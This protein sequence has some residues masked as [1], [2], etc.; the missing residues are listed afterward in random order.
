MTT[1][2]KTTITSKETLSEIPGTWQL[3]D[4]RS[5]MSAAGFAD[6]DTISE[7]ETR[8]M[9]LMA[10]ADLE[11]AEA[12]N[13]LLSYRLGDDL[14]DGQIDQISHDMQNDKI[15]EEY[16]EIG[17]HRHLFDANQLLRLAY[18]G[19][20][21]NGEAVLVHATMQFTGPEAPGQLTAGLVLRALAPALSD[22]SLIKRLY[23]ADL[24][25][26]TPFEAADNILWEMTA[27]PE[28]APGTFAVRL[29]SSEYWLHDLADS[30]EFEGEITLPE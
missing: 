29:V 22:R 20:F 19:K 21:P 9:T 15:F 25:A 1:S 23:A 14:N 12:A 18:N 10:L 24:E 17:L 16:P 3:T 26:D 4:Y 30:G 28:D 2:C 27:T 5:I 11:P 7:S 8:E 6:G 13:V